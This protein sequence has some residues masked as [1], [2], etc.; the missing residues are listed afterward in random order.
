ME[1][2][3][4]NSEIKEAA[5]HEAESQTPEQKEPEQSHDRHEVD[6]ERNWRAVRQRIAEL[7]RINQEKD[8]VIKKVLDSQKVQ[9]IEP[10]EEEP[11]SDDFVNYQGVKKTAYKAVEPLQ[12]KID[13]LEAKISQRQQQDLFESLKRK[14]PDFDEVV[15]PE[16]LALFDEKEP[17]LANQIAATKDPYKIGIQAYKFIKAS[18]FLNDLP[19][20]RHQKEAEKKIEKNANTVQSPQVYDKRPMAQAFRITESERSKLYEEMNHY[21]SQASSVPLNG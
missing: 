8:E 10:I 15:N 16:T 12:K 2:A 18:G 13:D 11:A 5:P 1:E 14:F 9:K 6:Q 21:A 3:E 4:V 17:E 7:E 20:K 19:N